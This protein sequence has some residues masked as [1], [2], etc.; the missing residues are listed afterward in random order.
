MFRQLLI[1]HRHFNELILQQ[2]DSCD[3]LR[4]NPVA[5]KAQ[6]IAELVKVVGIIKDKI[7]ADCLDNIVHEITETKRLCA[8]LKNYQISYVPSAIAVLTAFQSHTESLLEDPILKKQSVPAENFHDFRKDVRRLTLFTSMLKM[9]DTSGDVDLLHSNVINLSKSLGKIREASIQE[10]GG[11]VLTDHESDAFITLDNQKIK[12][13]ADVL[14]SV[15]DQLHNIRI[16]A[17]EGFVW[18]GVNH[19]KYFS[20]LSLCMTPDEQPRVWQVEEVYN[21]VKKAHGDTMRK[22]GVVRYFDH[23]R[24]VS[25]I[26]LTVGITDPDAHI[27]AL[28]HDAKE[29]TSLLGNGMIF[30]EELGRQ[31]AYGY[32]SRAYSEAAAEA[33]LAVTKRPKTG[34]KQVDEKNKIDYMQGLQNG[35]DLSLL[36]KMADRLCNLRSLPV[37]DE[38]FCIKQLRETVI[39]YIPIFNSYLTRASPKYLQGAEKLLDMIHE[40]IAIKISYFPDRINDLWPNLAPQQPVA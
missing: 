21:Q 5:R 33:V 7:E 36:I 12:E 38:R 8:R 17:S 25:I 28:Y 13:C 40:E 39:E 15:L 9:A 35:S 24:D 29:D 10:S 32:I 1:K 19:D 11:T 2:P 16:F 30:G 27:A 18:A 20:L 6:E 23:V 37:D 26:L 22:D 34:D 3:R 14:K 31:M 4:L